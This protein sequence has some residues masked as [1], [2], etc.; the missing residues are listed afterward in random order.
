MRSLI[1]DKTPKAKASDIDWR[2]EN[3]EAID[4]KVPEHPRKLQSLAMKR[5]QKN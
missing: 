3:Y 1:I 5:N 4:P 2:V